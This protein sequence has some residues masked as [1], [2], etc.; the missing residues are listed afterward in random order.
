MRAR[1]LAGFSISFLVAACGGNSLD[2]G[3]GN[4]PGTGTRTLLVDAD[5]QASPRQTNPATA[6]GFETH[7]EVRLEK[8]GIAITTGTVTVSSNGGDIA[9]VFQSSEN[10]WWGVQTGYHE[11]YE[12]NVRSGDDAVEAVRLDGPSL[13]HFTAPA[14][15][16]T[17]DA[18][19]PLAVRWDRDEAADTAMFDTEEMDDIAVADT[20]AFEVPVGGLRSNE[21]ETEQERLRLDRHSRIA[22]AGAV[23]GSELRVEVR[24]EI[25]VL[26]APTGP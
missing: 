2:P 24:N 19:V 13:H 16:A 12:L 20:G 17:V 18:T 10:R 11:V 6:D 4:D 5:V 21:G 9:L 26:V 25:D 22:P 1:S 8:N 3:A 14:A 15:G 7:V 23:A